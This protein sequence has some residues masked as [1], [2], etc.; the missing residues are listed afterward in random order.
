MLDRFLAELWYCYK[1]APS[2]IHSDSHLSL[3]II[4]WLPS[5]CFQAKNTT[6]SSV[7]YPGC[8][9]FFFPMTA[10]CIVF[11]EWM[12]LMCCAVLL[13]S[14]A[15]VFWNYRQWYNFT[16]NMETSNNNYVDL[17][18]CNDI[19]KDEFRGN[20]E[21]FL[22]VWYLYNDVPCTFT[23]LSRSPV[24]DWMFLC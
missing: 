5:F 10:L 12:M 8:T 2:E 21:H 23:F 1:Y 13:P 22:S 3:F 18:W 11:P 15:A 6:I 19:Y 4:Y 9:P 16:L 14:L 7:L 24:W 20:G 17:H